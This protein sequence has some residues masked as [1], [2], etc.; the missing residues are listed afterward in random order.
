LIELKHSP[1]I[2]CPTNLKVNKSEAS[3]SNV[4][5]PNDESNFNYY[6]CHTYPEKCRMVKCVFHNLSKSSDDTVLYIE[7]EAGVHLDKLIKSEKDSILTSS[8]RLEV[9][10]IPY[11]IANE[12]KVSFKSEANT[13]VLHQPPP[14]LPIWIIIVVSIIGAIILFLLLLILPLW[15]CGFFRRKRIPSSRLLEHQ[16]QRQRLVNPSEDTN[17]QNNENK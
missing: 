8:F 12:T 6:N 16:A 5:V 11:L 13:Y 7:L 9:T 4:L 3:G 17:D 15:K 14:S 10:K 1:E 2:D